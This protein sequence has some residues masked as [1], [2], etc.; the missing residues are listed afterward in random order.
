MSLRIETVFQKLGN[1]SI[2]FREGIGFGPPVGD[3][4]D[5]CI[6]RNVCYD[7]ASHMIRV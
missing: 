5:V 7:E 3:E 6:D 1:G 2:L 4:T